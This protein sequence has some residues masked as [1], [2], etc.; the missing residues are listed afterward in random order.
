PGNHW[1]VKTVIPECLL[2][3]NCL[4][5]LAVSAFGDG[6]RA[7]LLV[8]ASSYIDPHT[9]TARLYTWFAFTD[10]LSHTI[11]DPFLQAMWRLGLHLQDPW[12][13][14]PILVTLLFIVL[15]YGMST[16]LPKFSDNPNTIQDESIEDSR[17]LL[18]SSDIDTDR[19]SLSLHDTD[20]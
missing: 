16:M 17:S 12:L 14:L 10:A 7:P 2:N 8:I 4:L 19:Q 18:P 13:T 9:E 11:G 15:G 6:I 20:D 5:G 1:R 3:T